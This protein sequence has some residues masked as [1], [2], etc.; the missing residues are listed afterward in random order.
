[1][2]EEY[3]TLPNII[4]ANELQHQGQP[5]IGDF[6]IYQDGRPMNFVKI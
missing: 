4:R 5:K 6:H 3:I 1:M 2:L